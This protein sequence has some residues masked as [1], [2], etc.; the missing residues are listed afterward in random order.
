V[1]LDAKDRMLMEALRDD[2]RITNRRLASRVGLSPSACLSRVRR[3]EARGYIVGYRTILARAG[4]GSL[5][6]GWADIRLAE[7]EAEAKR[8]LLQLISGTPEIV[9]AHRI[10]GHSDYALR[11]CAGGFDAW[12][13]FRRKLEEAG[14]LA[15]A[16]FSILVEALK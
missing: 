2:A 12:N 6:E 11:F 15:H 5:L 13:D 14:C 10:S 16:R 4:A 3:L 8:Q 9:E 7:P 1:K